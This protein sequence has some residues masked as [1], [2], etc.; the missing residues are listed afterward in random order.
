[1]NEQELLDQEIEKAVKSVG[2]PSPPGILLELEKEVKKD[3]PDF[4]K[5]EQLVVADV[6]LSAM[7]LK[8]INSPL[9]GMRNKAATVRQAI[10]ILGL[11]ALTR[12]VTGL[13][14][15]TVLSPPGQI[16]MER[17]WDVSAKIAVT[18]S[19]LAKQ[20]PGMDKDEAYTF[21]LFQ[22]CGIPVLMQKFPGYK[23]TLGL[24]NQAADRK[25]TDVEDER[26]QTNHAT[27]GYILT[28]S[29]NLP[30]TLSNAI[31]FHHEYAMLSE[32]HTNLSVESQNLI[33]LA[34]LAEHIIQTN[35]GRPNSVEW[36]KAGP[37]ALNHLGLSDGEFDEIVADIKSMGE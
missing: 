20:L 4:R 30:A 2:I 21:G 29:W 35:S 19:Y 12:L 13:V 5:I 8:T 32:P 24:A 31:C 27:V 11:S 6:G 33:A 17:F 3:D 25:F 14:V 1:M 28:K 7:L 23:E 36:K 18:S 16:S 26:H 37:I 34:L 9:Y 22:D 15:R 10:S